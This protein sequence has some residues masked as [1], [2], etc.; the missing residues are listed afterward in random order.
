MT[1]DKSKLK[2]DV[3]R[4]A[5]YGDAALHLT[6]D[7]RACA[8]PEFVDGV[9]AVIED[10]SVRYAAGPPGGTDAG[11]CTGETLLLAFWRAIEHAFATCPRLHTYILLFDKKQWVPR[12]KAQ[13]QQSRRTTLAETSQR[14]DVAEWAWD[15]ASPIIAR[16]LPLPPWSRLR[17]NGAA[18]GRALDELVAL[19]ACTFQPPPG[20]R[21]IIDWPGGDLPGIP[22]VI[23]SDAATGAVLPAWRDDGLAN[24]VGEADLGAQRYARMAMTGLLSRGAAYEAGDVSLRSTDT[25]FFPLSLLHLAIADDCSRAAAAPVHNIWLNIGTCTVVLPR[26]FCSRNEAGAVPRGEVYSM[27]ALLAAAVASVPPDPRT[28]AAAV[29]RAA[30][31]VAFC[32]AAGNDYVTRRYG[33]THKVMHAAH[34]RSPLRVLWHGPHRMALV[35]LPSYVRFVRQCYWERL[36]PKHRGG[37]AAVGAADQKLSWPKIA[38]QTRAAFANDRAQLPSKDELLADWRRLAWAVAYACTGVHGASYVPA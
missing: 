37:A 27:R 32:T 23:E 14:R 20:R 2:I 26:K 21:I 22:L 33:L 36:G 17:L 34:C 12:Q 13:T 4:N 24:T 3:L 15:G 38:A 18:Y 16:A 25:D 5:P 11:S 30:A 28:T 10:G 9:R 31:F 19:M 6:D 7:V 8:P 29:D 1:T 35:T